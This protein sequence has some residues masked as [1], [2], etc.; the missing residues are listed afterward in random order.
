LP[1]LLQPIEIGLVGSGAVRYQFMPLT[2]YVGHA[3]G[4]LL[5]LHCSP[6]FAGGFIPLFGVE[7]V[8]AHC[9]NTML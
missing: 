6:E 8:G 9:A 3:G 2:S 1:R 4:L 7:R 5:P